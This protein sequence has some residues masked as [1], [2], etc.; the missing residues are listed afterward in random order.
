MPTQGQHTRDEPEQLSLPQLQT[1]FREV[2]GETT[3]C[4][5]KGPPETPCAPN[6]P[7]WTAAL[8]REDGTCPE[9]FARATRRGLSV[10]RAA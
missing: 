5:R 3:R 9:N 2:I 6:L 10:R 4:R 7:R 8:R 1:R